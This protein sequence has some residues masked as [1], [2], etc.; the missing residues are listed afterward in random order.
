MS[1]QAAPKAASK[2]TMENTSFQEV[3]RALV[4]K[5]VTIV[6]SESYESAPMGHQLR[7]GFYRAKV[8]G[9]GKD[10]LIVMTEFADRGK[11][12]EPVKQYIPLGQVKRISLMKAER[13]LHI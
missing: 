11:D 13:L 7:T 12:A 4:G 6:N 9:L 8:T 2:P 3:L 5:V 1:E 10:Y